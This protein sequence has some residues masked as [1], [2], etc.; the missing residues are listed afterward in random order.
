MLLLFLM[1]LGVGTVSGFASEKVESFVFCY[2][3][4]ELYPNFVG[5]GSKVPTVAPGVSIDLMKLIG[6]KVGLDV[7][8]VRFPWKRCLVLLEIGRVNGVIASYSKNRLAFGKF[9]MAFG[10]PD[11]SRRISTAGYYLYQLEGQPPLWDGESFAQTEG[12]IGAPLGYS[13]V[14][15]LRGQ[16]VKVIEAGN[17]IGLLY[18]L[19]RGRVSAVAAPGQA[20][21][22]VIKRAPEY[23][24]GI[25]RSNKPLQVKPYYIMLSNQFVKKSPQ[26]A[27]EIWSATKL[28]RESV[29]DQ[30][31]QQ[32]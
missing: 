8:F 19:K 3:D 27:E 31:I 10:I 18:M 14:D 23:F 28:L 17:A 9:P 7:K 25:T 1:F 32:Y 26:K 11:K 24:S 13:I 20:T 12:L 15:T 22:A 6:D 21:D 2:E 4:I 30:I 5:S 16:G 29:S